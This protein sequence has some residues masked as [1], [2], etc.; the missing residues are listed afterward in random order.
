[1]GF[2][3]RRTMQTTRQAILIILKEQGQATVD[4]LSAQLEVTPVTIR[5]HLDIL[6]SEGLVDTPKVKRL[7]TPGRPQHVYTLTEQ[8][9][10]HFPKNYATFADF[11]LT[12]VREHVG[13][14]QMDSIVRG[15]AHR[16]ASD[17]PPALPG[18]PLGKRLDQVVEFLNAKVYIA[19][20][21]HGEQWYLLHTV[22]CPYHGLTE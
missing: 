3:R 1:M 18:D 9:N 13:A 22:N 14:E 7:S 19:R 2:E 10:E 16:M 21:E 4:Q 8:A 12:E 11:T 15:V 20:W 17:A 6:R 5:H